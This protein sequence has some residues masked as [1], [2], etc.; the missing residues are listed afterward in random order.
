MCIMKWSLCLMWRDPKYETCAHLQEISLGLL[1]FILLL[2]CNERVHQYEN[3]KLQSW[4]LH[5]Q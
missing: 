5:V 1:I 2:L 3:E 4:R